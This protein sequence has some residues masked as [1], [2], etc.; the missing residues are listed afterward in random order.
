MIRQ[1][2]RLGR[3]NKYDSDKSATYKFVVD[4]YKYGIDFSEDVRRNYVMFRKYDIINETIYDTDIYFVPVELLDN[5]IIWPLANEKYLGFSLRESDF[6]P[7]FSEKTISSTGDEVYKLFEVD[8]DGYMNESKIPVDK[9]RIYHPHN[10]VT[11]DS[12]IYI[13]TQIGPVNVHLFCN[14]YKT[15]KTNAETEF[16][17]DNIIFS[18]FIELYIPNI[19][20]LMSG[21]VYIID[22]LNNA[23]IS[24]KSSSLLYK[25]GNLVF[26][27]LKLMTI[28]YELKQ[29]KYDDGSNKYYFERHYRVDLTGT[30]RQNYTSYPIEVL[31]YPYKEVD[32]NTYL[33]IEDDE[34]VSNS[35]IFFGESKITLMSSFGFDSSSN[36]T[37]SIINKFGF[38]NP[39]M[40]SSFRDAYQYYFQVDLNDYNDIVNYDEENDDPD[41]YVEEKQCGFELSLWADYNLTSPITKFYYEIGNPEK[42]LD[43]F[44]FSL[45]NIFTY[46]DQLPDVFVCRCRFIDKYLGNIITGN[47]V[48]ISKEMFKYLINSE[49]DS[50]LKIT[51]VQ[52]QLQYI[53][54]MDRSKYN[55]IDKVTC[56]VRKKNDDKEAIIQEQRQARVLYKPVFYKTQDLQN[57]NIRLGLKQNIGIA[58]SEY[59]TKVS[60]FKLVIGKNH[61]IETARNDIYVIFNIDATGLELGTGVYHI[62]NQDDEYISSG[63]YNII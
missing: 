37:P 3:Y 19:E 61:Y 22:Y 53:S 20:Y 24:D 54:D 13:K 43:N 51:G 50:R 14:E 10:L 31:L 18:E 2:I 59:M 41:D 27:S 36:G 55:F 17:E 15:F 4:L 63:N 34:L 29:T 6:N 32:D 16:T 46:W 42:T 26:T 58:L 1:D 38:P 23:T 45:R 5:K 47:D 48:Y 30:M 33:Y 7:N 52:D 11:T 62:A 9:I 12:I 28:P 56:I 39:T 35:D 49:D 57:I 40:F 25:E 8:N 21:N 44:A 60:S